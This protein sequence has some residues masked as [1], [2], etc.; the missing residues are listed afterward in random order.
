MTG[1]LTDTKPILDRNPNL[2]PIAWPF[3]GPIVVVQTVERVNT[4]RET[5]VAQKNRLKTLRSDCQTVRIYLRNEFSVSASTV[6][7]WKSTRKIKE[8]IKEKKT[9][10]HTSRGSYM[11]A[12]WAGTEE[13]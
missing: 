1:G 7:N 8:I 5:A 4:L 10:I 12:I 13:H 9:K 11:K 2:V 6:R 3:S